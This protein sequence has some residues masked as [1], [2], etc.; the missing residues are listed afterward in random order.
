LLAGLLVFSA[1]VVASC[2]TASLGRA[3]SNFFFGFSDD[4]PKWNGAD[5]AAPGRM[6]G[7]GAFRITLGW[8]TGQIDAAALRSDFLRTFGTTHIGGAACTTGVVSRGPKR[9]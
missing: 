3:G 2:A 4:G 8:V 6:I 5:A 7:A 1:F 9:R